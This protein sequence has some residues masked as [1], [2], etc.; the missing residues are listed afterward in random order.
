MK[1][2]G[3]ARAGFCSTIGFCTSLLLMGGCSLAPGGDKIESLTATL[4]STGAADRRSYNDQKAE[5]LLRLP[6]DI[7]IGA[8]FRLQNTVQQEALSMLCSG[9]RTY[10]ATP[11][12]ATDVPRSQS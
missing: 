9:R 3:K 1:D 11:P 8:Y 12:L 7:S 2:T 10:E 6:C 5:T 4:T